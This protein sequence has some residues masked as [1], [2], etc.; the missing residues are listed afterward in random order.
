MK[1]VLAMCA[2][3]AGIGGIAAADDLGGGGAGMKAKLL[4]KYDANGDGK[5]DA[6][7]RAQMRADFKAK[8]TE[9]KAE[10]LAKYDANKDGKLEPS[11]RKVMIDDRAAKQ[12]AK[13]DAN[14]D[15]QV[16]L[17]EFQAFKE[18][19]PMMRHARWGKHGG[20]HRSVTAGSREAE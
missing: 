13:L 20:G 16:S 19:H 12:F 14:G 1:V 8:R 3:L 7:E 11:E 18:A 5:L 2:A 9:R 10:R 4:Q 15:G 6:Q 17:A